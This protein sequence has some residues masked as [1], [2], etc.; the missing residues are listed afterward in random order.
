MVGERRYFATTGQL[1][2]QILRRLAKVLS[3]FF[4]YGRLT[5]GMFE[6]AVLREKEWPSCLAN[7]RRMTGPVSP[8]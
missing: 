7:I 6:V 8:H 5:A 4:A 3:R 1:A 2:A